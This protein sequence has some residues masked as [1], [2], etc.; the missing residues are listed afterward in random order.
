MAMEPRNHSNVDTKTNSSIDI[1]QFI[2]ISPI[3]GSLKTAGSINNSSVYTNK[4]ILTNNLPHSK[5]LPM[6]M[7]ITNTRKITIPLFDT[8]IIQATLLEVAT[9]KLCDHKES[10]EAFKT[11][12][13]VQIFY[14]ICD[15]SDSR[16]YP[17]IIVPGFATNKQLHVEY[18][19]TD[20]KN[21]IFSST[22]TY[23]DI[24]CIHKMQIISK[25]LFTL[26]GI[27]H[28]KQIF[29]EHVVQLLQIKVSLPDQ[30]KLKGTYKFEFQ[31][32]I[33]SS[34]SNITYKSN[35]F[36]I[37]GHRKQKPDKMTDMMINPDN[38]A[39]FVLG[40]LTSEPR[41]TD[42]NMEINRLNEIIN[43]IRLFSVTNVSE[44]KLIKL[45][46]IGDSSVRFEICHESYNQKLLLKV[47]FNF[48]NNETCLQNPDFNEL[49]ILNKMGAHPNIV[50]LWSYSIEYLPLEYCRAIPS[51]CIYSHFSKNQS[52]NMIFNIAGVPI[53]KI[54]NKLMT[55]DFIKRVLEELL[56][57]I[58]HLEKNRIVHR[59]INDQHVLINNDPKSD[60]LVT[61]IGFS[62]AVK[63]DCEIEYHQGILQIINIIHNRQ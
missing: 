19:I 44:F 3:N 46:G 25:T 33:S 29:K 2:N 34:N 27:A 20:S 53:N 43:M 7:G 4:E 38:N 57:A 47:H 51:D 28:A 41:A 10:T 26:H 50:F 58:A 8:P 49:H 16:K 61:L 31:V 32:V 13:T 17:A 42:N 6:S 21:P 60:T 12:N 52:L 15:K 24:T 48:N 35:I 45:H 9:L 59:D 40:K 56:S 54:D 37:D 30:R 62:F 55:P 39:R 36:T 18:D 22:V 23:D 63:C 14:L 11:G 1:S 5:A